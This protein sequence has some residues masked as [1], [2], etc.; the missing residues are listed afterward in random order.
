MNPTGVTKK[1]IMINTILAILLSGT[2]LFQEEYA[3]G[4]KE[5]LEFMRT[6][7]EVKTQLVESGLSEKEATMATAIVCPELAVNYNFSDWAQVKILQTIYV[8]YNRSDFSIGYFQ[9]KPS[10][11]EYLERT[12]AADSIMYAKYPEIIIRNP[13]PTQQRKIRVARL[14][15]LKWQTKFLCVF[16]Y[17]AKQRKNDFKTDDE[18]LAY[19]ATLYNAGLEASDK[20]IYALQ[21]RTDFPVIRRQFNYADIVNIFYRELSK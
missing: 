6:H 13:D 19:W 9:M 7:Q 21:K 2:L 4:Y 1:T 15:S 11:I 16:M 3:K 17:Y 20:T 14:V 12:V 5:A 8:Q 18:R 10:F